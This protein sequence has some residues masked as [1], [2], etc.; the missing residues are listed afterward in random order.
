MVA[1][2]NVISPAKQQQKA[3]TDFKPCTY[4]QQV[5]AEPRATEC[6]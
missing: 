6:V 2:I 1:L 5:A 4:V 3:A